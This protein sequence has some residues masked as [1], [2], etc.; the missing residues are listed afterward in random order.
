MMR[1][2]R[3][4]LIGWGVSATLLGIGPVLLMHDRER[5][6][7]RVIAHRLPQ[8]SIPDAELRHFAADFFSQDDTDPRK[9]ALLEELQPLALRPALSA[10][11]PQA[12][13]QAY[14]R[15]ERRLI[16]A[17]LHCTDFDL[18]QRPQTIRYVRFYDPFGPQV[19]NRFAR[20]VEV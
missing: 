14:Q 15:F 20:L 13:Q 17:L 7:R 12:M 1:L 8:V 16:T 10:R 11:L 3:R 2:S 5:I 18:S 6:L 4:G 9:L 19:H